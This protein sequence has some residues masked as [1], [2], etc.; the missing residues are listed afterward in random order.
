MNKQQKKEVNERLKLLIDYNQ[1]M[2]NDWQLLKLEAIKN[3]IN[4]KK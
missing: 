4:T 3:I 2:D 1:T